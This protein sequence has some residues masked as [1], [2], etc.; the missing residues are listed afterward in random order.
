MN[1]DILD[2]LIQDLPYSEYPY[3]NLDKDYKFD[4][5]LWKRDCEMRADGIY[6]PAYYVQN[7]KEEEDRVEEWKLLCSIEKY[8]ELLKSEALNNFDVRI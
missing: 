4:I 2:D 1:K 7:T 6:M 3:W 8:N 5:S